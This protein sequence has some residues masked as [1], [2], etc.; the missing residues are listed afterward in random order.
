MALVIKFGSKPFRRAAMTDGS[1]ADRFLVASPCGTIK[2]SWNRRQQAAKE[3]ALLS[4]VVQVGDLDGRVVLVDYAARQQTTLQGPFG[5]AEAY[6]Q[7]ILLQERGE[8]AE[9]Y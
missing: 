1:I 7:L 2:A 9:N 6:R 5:E 3:A 8:W 4:K